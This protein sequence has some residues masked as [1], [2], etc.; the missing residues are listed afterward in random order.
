MG[1]CAFWCKI[2][3]ASLFG[4]GMLL[5]AGYGARLLFGVPVAKKAKT[6]AVRHAFGRMRPGLPVSSAVVL[7]AEADVART[8]EDL[9]LLGIGHSVC[10]SKD[11]EACLARAAAPVLVI[12]GAVRLDRDFAA[13]AKTT[14][15]YCEEHAPAW[16]AV[17]VGCVWASDAA[18]VPNYDVLAR[19]AAVRA[20]LAYVLADAA[21]VS[22]TYGRPAESALDALCAGREVYMYAPNDAVVR[23]GSR[24]AVLRPIE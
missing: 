13:I 2:A 11:R 22:A 8:V 21:A 18:L 12:E 10:D 24:Q 14:L 4:A 7:R 19:P 1:A 15:H 5:V 3:L 17:V 9:N 23:V 6:V 20:P 16:R